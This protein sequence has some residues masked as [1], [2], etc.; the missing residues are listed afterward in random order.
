MVSL[1]PA[2]HAGDTQ[3]ITYIPDEVEGLTFLIIPLAGP[4][5]VVV[6]KP[7]K[8]YQDKF[9][10]EFGLKALIAIVWLLAQ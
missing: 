9:E 4:E 10:D 8:R 1:F 5:K 7:L 2:G 3:L 6:T